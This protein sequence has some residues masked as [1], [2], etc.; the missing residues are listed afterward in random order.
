MTICAVEK[1]N[2]SPKPWMLLPFRPLSYDH[3]SVA[4]TASTTDRE[5]EGE[6]HAREEPSMTLAPGDQAAQLLASASTPRLGDGP[7]GASY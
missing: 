6:E 3:I 4:H 7:V 1:K 5:A 2:A